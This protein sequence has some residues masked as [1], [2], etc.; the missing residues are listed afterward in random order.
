[1][2]S[3]SSQGP[4]DVVRCQTAVTGTEAGA[5]EGPLGGVRGQ[6]MRSW[7]SAR[8]EGAHA[9]TS[10]PSPRLLK[11]E[12]TVGIWELVMPRPALGTHSLVKEAQW[13]RCL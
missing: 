6:W 2:L 8:R 7:P 12:G 1:M 9:C 11:K 5:Q 3:I 4:V 13:L 10:L